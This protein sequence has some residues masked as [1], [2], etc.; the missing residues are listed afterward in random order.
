MKS[1]RSRSLLVACAVAGMAALSFLAYPVVLMASTVGLWLVS[2]I[3]PAPTI[4]AAESGFGF[5]RIKVVLVR[6][7]AFLLRQ[8]Q[9]ARPS[10]SR[11]WQN[12]TLA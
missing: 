7:K 3:A 4:D 2:K 5:D 8:A 12:V 11:S 10:V 9:R 6:A 1:F